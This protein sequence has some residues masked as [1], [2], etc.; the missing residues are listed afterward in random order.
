M[1]MLRLMGSINL[2]VTDITSVRVGFKIKSSVSVSETLYFSL[3]SK[4]QNVLSRK[5]EVPLTGSHEEF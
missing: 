3:F 4:Y 2:S 5:P 1:T